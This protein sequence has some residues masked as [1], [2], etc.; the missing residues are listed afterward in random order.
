MNHGNLNFMFV[1]SSSEQKENILIQH[2]EGQANE[3]TGLDS[4]FVLQII[5]LLY[6]FFRDSSHHFH[7]DPS[8]WLPPAI[9][10]V[11]R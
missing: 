5:A 9:S 11:P 1:K 8:S 3:Q 10:A 7:D 2:T 4:V 6:T